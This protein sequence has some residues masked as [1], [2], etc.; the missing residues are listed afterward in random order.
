MIM[1]AKV[2]AILDDRTY[3]AR[4][5]IVDVGG[6]TLSHRLALNFDGHAE[7]IDSRDIIQETLD[8]VKRT[9]S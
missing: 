3:V 6:W 8:T 1:A 7:G 5:D 4:E 2:R 9:E